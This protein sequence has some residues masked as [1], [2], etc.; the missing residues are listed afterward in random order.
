MDKVQAFLSSVPGFTNITIG[1]SNINVLAANLGVCQA[2]ISFTNGLRPPTQPSES[3]GATTIY[4]HYTVSD[5][6]TY[7][8]S[9]NLT[10]TAS[11]AFANIADQLGNPY[12]QV[13]NVTGV[14]QYTYLSL[15]QT[16][17]SIVSGISTGA[18]ALAK[19]RGEEAV[20]VH[21]LHT[22]TVEGGKT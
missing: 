16:L 18:N 13:V 10:L 15:N 22:A 1:A 5:G 7:S 20:G 2:P 8:V 4:F 19:A 17:T 11:S 12:Q 3:N 21:H 6:V 9:A 14:R